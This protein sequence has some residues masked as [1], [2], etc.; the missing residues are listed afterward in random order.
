MDIFYE[1][2]GLPYC[3]LDYQE[4]FL[5]KCDDCHAAIMDVSVCVVVNIWSV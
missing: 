4:L 3:E 2:D 1:N 5:P